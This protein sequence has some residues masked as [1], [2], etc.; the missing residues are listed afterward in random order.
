MKGWVNSLSQNTTNP[1]INNSWVDGYFPSQTTQFG[2][3]CIAGTDEWPTNGSPR[4]PYGM[5]FY[6]WTEPDYHWINFKRN[7]PNHWHSDNNHE[8]I[9]YKPLG[10]ETTQY[11]A[12]VNEEELIVG[13]GYMASIGVE[14]FMQSHGTLNAGPRSIWVTNSEDSRL[15]GWN[16]VGNP[17]HAYLDFDLLA[18]DPTNNSILVTKDGYP[19]Y[20][21]YNADKYLKPDGYQTDIAGTAFRYYPVGSSIGGDY[22]DQFL[23]PH[24]GFYVRVDNLSEENH[25][26]QFTEDM[27][28]TRKDDS[29]FRHERPAYPLVNLYLSSDNGCAD[30]TVIELE[31]PEWGGAHKMKEL[32]V[33]N[34]LFYGHHE[35]ENYAA[36]FVKE[37]TKQVPVRFEAKEDDIFTMKW[38]TANGDFHSMYL[39]DNI[40]GV[41]YDMLRNDT[42]IFEGHKSDYK[43]RFLIVFEVTDVE[44]N[45]EGFHNFVFF[46]GS[47]WI[48]TGEGDLEFIDLLGRVLWSGH[49]TGGQTRISLPDVAKSLYMFRL[50]NANGTKVQ[51]V[52]VK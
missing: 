48:A 38:N 42:Y 37:G 34:G 9:D 52:L 6:T 49:L 47:Q 21:V 2:A 43:S 8:H 45:V 30:V 13:R 16:L 11:P 19:F 24:Q 7:G 28:V 22:A 51:K 18:T 31:R 40:A 20:V 36:L 14:T 41:Q 44:E 33:G 17:Y 29:H 35:D 12:N 15:P 4:Y 1:E 39:I 46:D 10:E 23:H 32:R 3:S 25:A 5:D 27:L 50:T 26:L